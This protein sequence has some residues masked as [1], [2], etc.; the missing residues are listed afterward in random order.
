MVG[1]AT[2]TLIQTLIQIFTISVSTSYYKTLLIQSGVAMVPKYLGLCGAPPRHKIGR[3][4]V[5]KAPGQIQMAGMCV[6]PT[7]VQWKLM[8]S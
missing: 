5:V 2:P 8:G 6:L 7:N 3:G 4:H 1:G